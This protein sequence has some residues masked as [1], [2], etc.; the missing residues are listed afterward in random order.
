MHWSVVVGGI[1]SP[2]HQNGRWGRLLS[3]GAPD[4]P[5]PHRTLSGAPVCHPTVRVRSLELLTCGPPDNLVVHQTGHVHYPVRHLAPALTLRAQSALFNV[6]YRLLQTTVGAF[7][8]CS[9]GTP[10]SPV[11]RW[12]VRWIIAEWLPEFPKVASLE[13]ISLVHRTLS[14]GAPDTIR[15]HTGQFGAPD[16]GSLR[17]LCSFLFEPFLLTLYWFI[18]LNLWHL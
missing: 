13:S 15:W 16:Q 4:T 8:C 9:V 1:Y 5:V 10:D 7:S 6:H 12:I 18:V 17:L 2:N 11:L 3:Y 14:S